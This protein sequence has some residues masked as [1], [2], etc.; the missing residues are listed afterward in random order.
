MISLADLKTQCNKEKK[1]QRNS[2]LPPEQTI[3]SQGKKYSRLTGKAKP[4]KQMK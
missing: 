4:R 2:S 3:T 1:R